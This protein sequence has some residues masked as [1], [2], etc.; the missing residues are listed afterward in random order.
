MEKQEKIV[1]MF[2]QIAPT[3]DKANRIL[4]FGIDTS[5]R[6]NACN[7]VLNKFKNNHV[8]IVDIACGTGDMMGI[9][10]KVAKSLNVKINKMSGIDP[11][12]GML[13]VAKAKFPHYNFINAL[14]NFTT[15]ENSSS[16]I[17]SIS[18]GIRNVV[19][20]NDALK[21]FNRILKL[22]GYVVVL[23]FTKRNSNGVMCKIRDF[24]LGKI[25]PKIGGIISKN[26]EAYEYLP[27]SIDNF[28]DKN[29]FCHELKEA[30]FEI[31]ICKG[32]SFDIST[33]FIAK[34]VR[35]L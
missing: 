3:Y 14:A 27:N 24:Y 2:N 9:W 28:L 10:Q 20:R 35:E 26:R 5:W 30:G 4:S 21:E 29:S 17:L 6:K 19:A 1:Q 34:K 15:L 18:Y 12:T 23:E 11:S 33:L 8:D 31:E 13:E 7:L 32:Y 25:L 16:D 22:G